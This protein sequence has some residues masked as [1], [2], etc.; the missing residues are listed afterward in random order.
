MVVLGIRLKSG[1]FRPKGGAT[2][3]RLEAEPKEATRTVLGAGPIYSFVAVRLRRPSKVQT[4]ERQS[5]TPKHTLPGKATEP[6]V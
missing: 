3:K 6:N 4:T 5:P 1:V 2:L